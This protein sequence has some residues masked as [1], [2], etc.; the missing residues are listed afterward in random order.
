MKGQETEI[1]FPAHYRGGL[2]TVLFTFA[3]VTAAILRSKRNAI[4]SAITYAFAIIH[5]SFGF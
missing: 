1:G 3:V 2:F 4:T 5:A